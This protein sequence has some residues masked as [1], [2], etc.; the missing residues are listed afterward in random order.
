MSK[1]GHDQ[2]SIIEGI[3][4]AWKLVPELSFGLLMLYI[5]EHEDPRDVNDEDL[6]VYINDF[7]MNNM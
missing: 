5:M 3:R 1:Y 6:M 2:D 4:D 7:V